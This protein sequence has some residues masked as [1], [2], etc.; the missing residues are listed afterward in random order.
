VKGA[1]ATQA[2]IGAWCGPMT[3][4]SAYVLMHHWIGEIDGHFGAWGWVKGG[5]GAVSTAMAS[6]AEAAGAQIR[7]DAEV[8]RIAINSEGR[9]VGVELVDGSLVRAKQVVSNA[10]PTTTY[11]DLIG[12]ERLPE[13]VVHDIERFRTRSGSVKINIALS[14]L[15]AFPSWDQEGAVHRGLMAVSPSMEYLEQAFDDAKYGRASKHP[16]A[17]VMFP[18]AHEEGLAPSG[19]HLMM[20][21]TQYGPYE[22][23]R[24]SWDKERDAYAKRVIAELARYAPGLPD[25]VE[26]VEVLTPKDL[27]ERFGLLGGNIMQGEVVADQLFCFRPIPFYGD[28]RTPV[29]DLYLCGAGTHPGGGVMGVNGRNASTVILKD[30]R[31]G[32]AERVQDL[33]DRFLGGA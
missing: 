16:Y 3:P 5:M 26:H 19:K 33:R 15:P 31:G 6:A 21:F 27:E 1:L 22:L 17:E 4:G 25:A 29:R 14:E 28:Y 13:E 7:T 23:K 30:A 32:V 18:T 9:A 11:L 24:G 10:H 2:I 20:A 8:Q 12:R